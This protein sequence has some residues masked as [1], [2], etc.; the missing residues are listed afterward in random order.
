MRKTEFFVQFKRD[1][2]QIRQNS[3]KNFI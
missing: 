3:Y 1:Y 2:G